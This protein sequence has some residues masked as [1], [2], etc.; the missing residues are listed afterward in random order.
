[1]VRAGGAGG[2][3]VIN[4]LGLSPPMISSL[5]LLRKKVESVGGGQVVSLGKEKLE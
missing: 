2:L 1:M 4:G 5:Y 3:D